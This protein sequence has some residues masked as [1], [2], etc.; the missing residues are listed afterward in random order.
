MFTCGVIDVLQE[1]GV[2]FDGLI[3]VS[4]GAAFGC[5]YKSHQIGRA[6]R[7]NKRFARDRRY[8]GLWSLL[9]SGNIINAHFA[10]HVV[11]MEYDVFDGET[12]RRDPMEFQLVCTDVETGEAVYH[13]VDRFDAN[14]LEWIRASASMP[15]VSKP[16][17]LD[18]RHLLDGGISD[19]IPLRHHEEQGYERNVVVL[20][21]P[22]GY[23]KRGSRL[24]DALLRIFA[25]RYP[26]IRHAMH[27]RPAMYNAQLAYVR[28]QEEAGKAFVVCPQEPLNISRLESSPERLQEVYDMG[29]GLATELLPRIRAFLAETES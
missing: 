1:E 9:S 8:M 21:Q 6:L 15:G 24:Q 3:G 26:A 20:T 12:F 23:L 5:N 11:P 19:S 17:S 28:Q 2:R 22:M 14:A 4:A 10:Y 27:V 16:V 13:T 29:R 18:G 7:Y 25:R